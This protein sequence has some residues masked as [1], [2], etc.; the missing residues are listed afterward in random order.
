LPCSALSSSSAASAAATWRSIAS[1]SDRVGRCSEMRRAKLLRMVRTMLRLA[2]VPATE[3]PARA[4]CVASLSLMRV[5]T[6]SGS[7]RSSKKRLRNSSFE[8][9]NSK[10][11]CS[12]PSSGLALPRPPA[13]PEGGRSMRSPTTNFL[14]PG[15][16]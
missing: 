1:I 9:T 8:S 7:S 13:S 12:P 11:S 3:K 4:S 6:R 2:G 16:T 15:T 14:L 10:A 5:L